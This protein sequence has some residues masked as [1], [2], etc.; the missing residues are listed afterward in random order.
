METESDLMNYGLCNKV[1]LF[2]FGLYQADTK[3]DQ[4]EPVAMQRFCCDCL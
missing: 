2:S 1:S 4:E 3:Y